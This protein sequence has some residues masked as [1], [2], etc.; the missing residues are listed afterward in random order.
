MEGF[1][2]GLEKDVRI[3]PR[4]EISR[5]LGSVQLDWTKWNGS[6]ALPNTVKLSQICRD[7]LDY[8]SLIVEFYTIYLQKFCHHF[9]KPS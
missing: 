8:V 4:M 5:R 9:L 3:C 2:S 6:I 7:P 1:P